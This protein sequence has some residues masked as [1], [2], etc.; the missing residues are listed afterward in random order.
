[1]KIL[2]AEDNALSR[3]ILRSALKKIGY[4]DVVE[5]ENGREAWS[6][7][8]QNKISI[9][10]SDWMMPDINGLELCRRIRSED[11]TR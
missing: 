7:F 9:L 2:I 11:R 8:Q 4:E 3:L 6:V 1:M 10:I 5:T